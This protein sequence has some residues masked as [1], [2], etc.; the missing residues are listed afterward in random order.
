MHVCNWH[1][2][3]RFHL[4]ERDCWKCDISGKMH[5]FTHTISLSLSVSCMVFKFNFII[6]DTLQHLNTLSQKVLAIIK[7]LSLISCYYMELA[8]VKVEQL[9]NATITTRWARVEILFFKAFQKHIVV[10]YLTRKKPVKT[11]LRATGDCLIHPVHHRLQFL[12]NLL[13]HHYPQ[14]SLSVGT[15]HIH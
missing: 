7:K 2:S 13:R 14:H 15:M 5:S 4:L 8:R 10:S 3:C 1:A 6:M 12:P 11:D 9:H